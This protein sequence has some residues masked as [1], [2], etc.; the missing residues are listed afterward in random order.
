MEI[1]SKWIQLKVVSI[2]GN[3][4]SLTEFIRTRLLNNFLEFMQINA[5]KIF[6][7][8]ETKHQKLICIEATIVKTKN[9]EIGTEKN[10]VLHISSEIRWSVNTDDQKYPEFSGK[11]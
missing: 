7:S 10:L 4:Q 8:S 11:K 2:K 3:R 5:E 9:D 6:F 1:C